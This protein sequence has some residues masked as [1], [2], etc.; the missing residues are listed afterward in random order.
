MAKK[1]KNLAYLAFSII[2]IFIAIG[3][4]IKT[5]QTTASPSP[6]LTTINETMPSEL[7]ISLI[8]DIDKAR[9]ASN[10]Y[11][12]LD[13]QKVVINFTPVI[14]KDISQKTQF[15]GAFLSRCD[16]D[17][18]RA[19]IGYGWAPSLIIQTPGGQKTI[20]IILGY[21][22]PPKRLAMID[23][24]DP[25][26]LIQL[27]EG[28]DDFLKQWDNRTCVIFDRNISESAVKSALEKY[29][30]IEKASAIGIITRVK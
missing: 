26:R 27:D 15:T 17:T 12:I 23:F 22:D 18:L 4:S 7:P 21:N 9:Q 3:C 25:N 28:Y 30:P 1:M 13:P 19:L 24:K 20:R 8:L 5:P 6:K 2:V 29:L 10:V 14:L 11:K 16:I